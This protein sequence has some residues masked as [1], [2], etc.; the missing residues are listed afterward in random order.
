MNKKSGPVNMDCLEDADIILLGKVFTCNTD[1]LP[2]NSLTSIL[3]LYHKQKER[4]FESLSGEFVLILIDKKLNK[5]SIATDHIGSVPFFYTLSGEKLFFSESPQSL[6]KQTGKHQ[7]DQDWVKRFL[8]NKTVSPATTAYNHVKNIGPGTFLLLK[9]NRAEEVV[10]YDIRK[11][12]CIVNNSKKNLLETFEKLIIAAVKYR[13]NPHEKTGSELSGGI[14]STGVTGIANHLV[15]KSENLFT[16][17]HSLKHTQ[18]YFPFINEEK[19]IETSKKELKL[20]N[21][22][23]SYAEKKGIMAPLREQVERFKQPIQF[24]Y[25]LFL[26]EML[27]RAQKDGVELMLSG[28]GGDE[29]VTSHAQGIHLEY[30]KRLKLKKYIHF[31]KSNLN[32][33]TFISD[34]FSIL[35]PKLFFLYKQRKPN[36]FLKRTESFPLRDDIIQDKK[37]RNLAQSIYFPYQPDLSIREYMRVTRDHIAQRIQMTNLFAS[38]YNIHYSFPL[39]DKDLMEF[40]YSLPIQMKYN[41]VGRYIYRK[42]IEK[43]IPKEIAWREDKTGATIPNVLQRYMNDYE[44]IET[45]IEYCGQ[46]GIGKEYFDFKKLKDYHHALNKKAT[47]GE[48]SLVHGI[49]INYLSLLLFLDNQKNH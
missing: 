28:F 8:A 25:M 48:G 30:L 12:K 36:L 31:R 11:R 22:F 40:Y 13:I 23:Y 39:W 3:K 26:D 27:T 6:I 20:K 29:L 9:N 15:H 32:I 47:T 33:K 10:Y 1:P 16:Y 21:H 14:D 34:I 37:F 42:V 35:F 7:L 38:Q 24:R 44:E 43:Y 18:T 4:I 49:M 46:K 45:F 5:I 19:F 41:K 17:S 2:V